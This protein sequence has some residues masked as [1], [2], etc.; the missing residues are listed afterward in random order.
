MS[1]P[2]PPPGWHHDPSGAPRQRYW[3]GSRWTDHYAQNGVP[4]TVPA[5]PTTVHAAAAFGAAPLFPQIPKSKTTAILLAVFL[6]FWMW[7]Y[8]YKVDAWK[9]WLNLGLTVVTLGIWSL[10]AWPWSIIDAAR[11]SDQW[12]AQFPNGDALQRQQALQPMGIAGLPAPP[13]APPRVP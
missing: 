9:F 10:V 5:P 13:P 1:T 3:D 12:Y 7:I 11:R 6:A 2:L 4:T 8:T